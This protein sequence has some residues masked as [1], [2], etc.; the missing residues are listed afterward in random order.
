MDDRDRRLIP[1][2]SLCFG[3]RSGARRWGKLGGIRDTF[4]DEVSQNSRRR[5]KISHQLH[6]LTFILKVSGVGALI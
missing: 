4:C 5:P 3:K 6:S 2:I 1:G